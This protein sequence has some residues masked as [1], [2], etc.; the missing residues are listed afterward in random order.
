[1]YKWFRKTKHITAILFVLT[2][3]CFTCAENRTDARTAFAP[4]ESKASISTDLFNA[5]FMPVSEAEI[6]K[7]F[8]GINHQGFLFRNIRE[9]GLA[10]FIGLLFLSKLVLSLLTQFRIIRAEATDQFQK[11]T[12]LYI[13]QKSDQA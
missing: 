9:A 10:L 7:S 11:S 6:E 12:I 5:P 13:H 8:S 1:M 3:L 4:A 2:L